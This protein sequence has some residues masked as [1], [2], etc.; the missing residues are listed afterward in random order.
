MSASLKTSLGPVTFYDIVSRRSA[1][2]VLHNY[3]AMAYR[4]VDCDWIAHIHAGGV[5]V[6]GV[7]AK[8]YQLLLADQTVATTITDYHEKPVDCRWRL[9][10]QGD[11]IFAVHK[12][13]GLPVHRTSIHIYN[14]LIE[15][16]KRESEWP[17]AH[18]LHRLDTDTAGIILLGKDRQAAARWQPKI[19]QLMTRK[20][21]QAIVYGRPEWREYDMQCEL[22]TRD[23][24]VIS[25]QMFVCDTDE[26]G[27]LSHSHFLYLSGNNDF[28]IIEC[29]I[30][31][32]R[33]HQI[34]AQLA[35]LGHAI[36]GDKLYAHGGDYYLKRLQKTLTQEDEHKLLVPHHLLFSQR[37]RVDYPHSDASG[38]ELVDPHYSAAWLDFCQSQGL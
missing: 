37:L 3:I 24:S 20:I 10:W 16:V 12:P 27:K 38:I 35:H 30:F 32:G 2:Q 23:S 17:E 28:S 29:E 18:L 4:H 22:S 9:L 13:A 15:L 31:T 5:T 21:Y 6:D 7:V 1:G 25:A 33:K 19:Q 14:T 8:P 11:D 26:C 36:V 34:R